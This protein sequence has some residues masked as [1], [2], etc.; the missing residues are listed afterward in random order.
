MTPPV[1][2]VLIADDYALAQGVSAAII[3]L[4][5]RGRLS[6]TGAMTNQPGWP[7]LAP[8]LA[9]FK[10]V[11]DLGL[12]LTLTLG[13]PLG[14]MPNLAPQGVLPP[15]GLLMRHALSARLSKPEL[16]EEVVRQI[17]AFHAAMGRLPDFIDGHQHVHVLPTVRVAL[18][19]AVERVQP[20][21]RPWLRDPS[22]RLGAILARGVAVG[23]SMVIA[24]L[25]QGFAAAARRRGFSLNDS[26]S[27]VSDF[28][29]DGDFGADF[30]RYLLV[31]GRRHLIMCHPG[32][33]DAELAAFDPVTAS[34][35]QEYA[36]L[37]GEGLEDRL[38]AM[39]MRIARFFECV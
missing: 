36:F 27:G 32:H 34:R 35:D 38:A 25:A 4:L 1:P 11:R 21:W 9:A 2:F 3:D 39:N 5:E 29:V 37:G 8:A 23:K 24:L 20:G 26:F 33:S 16:V 18:F 12:H 13:R 22:D 7:V 30:G 28:A 6:G 14:P 10:G 17:E 15:L 31:G 19:D